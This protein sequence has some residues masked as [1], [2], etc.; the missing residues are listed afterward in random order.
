MASHTAKKTREAHLGSS[1]SERP[2]HSAVAWRIRHRACVVV[3]CV[4]VAALVFASTAVASTWISLNNAVQDGAVKTVFADEEKLDPNEGRPIKFVLIGQDTR[5]EGN[6]ELSGGM[7]DGEDNLHNADTTMVVDI[8]ADRNFINIVSIPRDSIVDVPDCRTSGGK[9][10]PAQYGVMFNSVFSTAYREGGD[11]STAASCTVTAVNALTG[12]HI[13]NFVVVDFKGLAD[14]IDAI[15]GVDVC[16]PVDTVDANTEMD[17]RKGMHHL[18]GR[19]ATNYARMRHGT[20][21]DGS[22]IMRTTRQQYLIK[23]VIAE[24]ISKNMF[25]Q[26]SELYQLALAAIRSLNISSGMADTNALVALA[27]SLRHLDVSHVYAQTVPVVP[28]PF[29]PN[30]VVWADSAAEVWDRLRDDRPLYGDDDATAAD[31][32][33]GD[34][35]DA[36]DAAATPQPTPSDTDGAASTQTPTQ[37]PSAK[38]QPTVDPKTGL[39]RQEDGTLIDPNTNGVVDP[40]TGSIRDTETGQYIGIAYQYLNTTICS[41]PA[42]SA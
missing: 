27:F 35:H 38:P 32:D 17:L 31:A 24:A 29:D 39:I 41:V 23:S 18:D 14:M 9:E 3:A 11:L 10:I 6:A 37:T 15:G 30:R 5:D 21:T 33:G 25:T 40:E 2:R 7:H 19:Q 26:T 36:G 16:I 34:D 13:T 28:A 20:G 8:S 4:V 1:R 12:M 42:K 22:D